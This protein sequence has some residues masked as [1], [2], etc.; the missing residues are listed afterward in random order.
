MDASSPNKKADTKV[1]LF[2]ESAKKDG[3]SWCHEV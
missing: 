1:Y 3:V 2:E